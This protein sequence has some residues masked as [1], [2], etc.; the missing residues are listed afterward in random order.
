[1]HGFVVEHFAGIG[2]HVLGASNVTVSDNWSGTD[3]S[4]LEG[5]GN[6]GDGIRI[7]DGAAVHV[8]SNVVGANG[9]HGIFLLDTTKSQVEA[10]KSGTN[11][12]GTSAL[13]NGLDGIAVDGGA[14]NR[15]AGNVA[16]GNAHQ[17]IAL[18]GVSFPSTSGNVVQDN[19]VGLA[20]ASAATIPNGGDGIR[21]FNG[22][23]NVIGGAGDSQPNVVSGNLGAGIAVYNAV[24]TGNSI[25]ANSVFGNTGLGIDLGG[26]GVTPNDSVDSDAGPNDLVNFPVLAPPVVTGT[27][28]NV[29]GKY[30]GVPNTRYAIDAY[31]NSACH[32]GRPAFGDGQT[33][34]GSVNVST[35]AAGAAAIVL[36]LT[37]GAT[38]PAGV[39]LTAT[40][41]DRHETSEFS[42]C[43]APQVAGTTTDSTLTLAS[44]LG[45]SEAGAS[46]VT[47]AGIPRG[48]FG[49]P[50]APIESSPIESSPIESSPIE[51]SPIES[52]PIESSPIESSPIESSPIESSPIESSP[53]ESS[54]FTSANLTQNR[55]GGV[56]LSDLPLL[57]GK[58]WSA[59]LGKDVPEQSTTLAGAFALSPRPA[60]LNTLKVGDI[61]WAHSNSPL[62]SLG[63]GAFAV[64]PAKLANLPPKGDASTA[65]ADWC[66]TI[67]ALQGFSCSSPASLANTTVM[68]IALEGVPIESSGLG[69][70]PIESSDL[71]GTPIESSPIESSNLVGTPIESSALSAIDLSVSPFGDIPLSA[72][73]N[74][75]L[76]S[77]LR[78]LPL[79]SVPA[80][81]LTCVGSACGTKLG[82]ATVS[83]NAKVRDLGAALNTFTVGDLKT[84]P[85]VTFGNIGRGLPADI[86]LRDLL[87]AL[88][89]TVP[90]DPETLPLDGIQTV[91][92]AGGLV[93]Y[94]A[95]LTLQGSLGGAFAQLRAAISAGARYKPGST[96]FSSGGVSL[97][98]N[99]PGVIDGQLAWSLN[100]LTYGTTYQLR[101]QVYP[102]LQ[103]GTDTTSVSLL[104][105]ASPPKTAT[106]VNV[107]VTDTLE[108]S[109]GN[110]TPATAAPVLPG[111]LYISFE[112]TQTD[113]DWY[114][115]PVPAAGSVTTIT[116]SHLTNDKD[117][118]VYAPASA[119]L[120]SAPIES[121]PIESSPI[122]SSPVLDPKPTLQHATD[123]LQPA[124][125]QDIP[126]ESS[127]LGPA[128]SR[129]SPTTPARTST[130]S[131]SYRQARR[132]A[133]RI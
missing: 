62:A 88:F 127:Q 85:G 11:A 125:V 86:N 70:V 73:L 123:Q 43:R 55:L 4:G 14:G 128:S 104:P 53:I 132:R 59:V 32:T 131:R 50:P 51:S 56:P 129:A 99:D 33:W 24:S 21:V 114:S 68:D 31:T 18:F 93:T 15:I 57:H 124:A 74:P 28:V 113:T 17:G 121:S 112:Q 79:S 119:P 120:R 2:I 78:N 22:V 103:L 126:I 76:N 133:R 39:T 36:T 92:D 46:I 122:E 84:Y 72:V 61:D 96:I 83:P 44:N 8:Q 71:A 20:A 27:T 82:D 115:L 9:G 118:V 13:A 65:L 66:A 87:R 48:A 95:T 23:D 58:T 106:P 34:K 37:A 40:D 41:L 54:G 35:D 38:L 89:D 19:R 108:G 98:T 116:L 29:S 67:D 75:G 105:L 30:L 91:A 1:M 130:P 111:K 49:P 52:S 25:R 10:N 94:T 45:S 117:I 90:F 102:G 100:G 26:D 109:G 97:A 80:G 77:P 107:A 64:G 7:E 16:S 42:Q 6:S 110:N 63:V 3:P 81:I 47:L 12:A 101:F 69:T 5:A 60:G